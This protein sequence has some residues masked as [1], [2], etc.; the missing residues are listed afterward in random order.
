MID[1]SST[2]IFQVMTSAFRDLEFKLLCR[3]FKWWKRIVFNLLKTKNPIFVPSVLFELHPIDERNAIKKKCYLK[4]YLLV[5]WMIDI[6]TKW[7]LI[8]PFSWRIFSIRNTITSRHCYLI[9]RCCRW[10]ILG[11]FLRGILAK[12]IYFLLRKK[13]YFTFHLH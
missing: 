12:S 3:D 5:K 6:P 8:V 10:S 11:G 7:D 4:L 1:A 9:F 2:K 13:H